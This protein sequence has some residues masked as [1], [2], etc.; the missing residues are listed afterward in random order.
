[1]AD[2]GPHEQLN[3]LATE[4]VARSSCVHRWSLGDWALTL[5]LA[6]LG[7]YV[8]R[9]EP[10][11]RQLGPQ[12]CRRRSRTPSQ[13]GTRPSVSSQEQD[14]AISYRHT[15]KD[16]ARVPTAQLYQLAFWLPLAVLALVVIIWPAGKFSA[17]K[18]RAMQMNQ[19]VLGL[20]SSIA[21]ALLLVCLVKNQVGRLRPDFLDRCKLQNGVCT[22]APAIVMEGRELHALSHKPKHVQPAP[23]PVLWF[24]MA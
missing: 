19:A 20:C 4:G 13:R 8:D 5:L 1:M 24:E 15:P 10:F 2:A 23:H 12:V 9:A 18:D 14:P 16:Q 21:L 11:L 17:K 6:L 7:C 22:G 3:L